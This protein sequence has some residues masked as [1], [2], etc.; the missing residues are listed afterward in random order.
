MLSVV[1]VLTLSAGAHSAEIAPSLGKVSLG[2]S[3]TQVEAALG[4][5]LRVIKTDD[6]LDPEFQ[7]QGLKVWFWD[8]KGVAQIRSTSK[9]HCL[10]GG[11]CPGATRASIE[12]KLGKPIAQ[13]G[14]V[15][16]YPVQSEACWLEVT[17]SG[18]TASSM[19]IACQL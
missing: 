12:S 18:A 15:I 11:I 1:C 5:P 19:E 7:Y 3:Q 14:N 2:L 8:G 9:T 17:F 6:A 10:N 13:N 16:H 4:K